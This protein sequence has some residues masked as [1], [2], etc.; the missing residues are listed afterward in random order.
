MLFN[1]Y[2]LLL[3]SELDLDAAMSYPNEKYLKIIILQEIFIN[4]ATNNKVRITKLF[5]P[6][7]DK[8]LVLVKSRV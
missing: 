4:N 6:M 1:L 2:N 3:Y 8:T 7:F 5:R